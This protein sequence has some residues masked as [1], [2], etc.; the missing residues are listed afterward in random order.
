MYYIS[1]IIN[2]KYKMYDGV[3][4]SKSNMYTSIM[5]VIKCIY[6]KAL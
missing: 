6:M 3:H 2:I 4:L 1:C 5:N